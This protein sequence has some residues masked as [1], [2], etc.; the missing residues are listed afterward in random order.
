MITQ[1]PF[2]T[3]PPK[4]VQQVEQLPVHFEARLIP[5]GDSKLK[6]E[7]LKNGKPIQASNRISTMHDFGFVSLDLKWVTVDDSG[8][9]TCRAINELGQAVTSANLI[10]VS[11]ADAHT[12]HQASLEKIRMLE[13]DSRYRRAVEEEV[14]V[15]RPPR[16]VTQVGGPTDLSEGQSSHYE[17]RIEPYPDDSMKVEWFKDGAPL[18]SGHRF[19]PIYDFGFAALDLL[20]LLAEDSGEY[21]CKA[22]N[23]VGS[24]TSSIRINVKRKLPHT[25]TL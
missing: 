6:V 9:Y 25:L 16:F 14:V 13:D 8:T 10:V 17:C 11:K 21:T 12:L 24:A 5:V 20:G 18:P 19:R 2:F 7:W 3:Q 22:T 4:N 15:N 1:A 23:R